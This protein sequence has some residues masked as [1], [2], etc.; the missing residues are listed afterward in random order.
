MSAGLLSRIVPCISWCRSRNKRIVIFDDA[1]LI[2]VPRPR[3]VNFIKQRIYDSVDAVLIP[4]ESH[5]EDYQFWGVKKER[6]FYGINVVDNQWFTDRIVSTGEMKK[7]LRKE[8]KLPRPFFLCVGRFIK[9]K[10]WSDVLLAYEQVR[11]DA[12]A[13]CPDLVLVGDGPEK[14]ALKNIVESRQIQGVVFK[15]FVSQNEICKYYSLSEM[16]ILASSSETW[17]LVV[18]EA[19]AC[20]KPVLVSNQCGCASTLVQEG[21]NGFTF[22][23]GNI[24]KMAKKMTAFNKLSAETKKQMGEYSKKII[25]QWPLER[26]AKGAW[27]AISYSMEN[28]KPRKKIL[29]D[30]I[31]KSWK[32]RYRPV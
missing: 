25:D 6:I 28:P 3:F 9:E 23:A 7:N 20:K 21:K 14:K 12:K 31:I 30:L 17:G 2:D 27:D 18:N 8:L 5:K 26:F 32:G 19:M 10:R 11:S 4:A 1:R 24:E 13:D 22:N 16:L 15:P 29:D